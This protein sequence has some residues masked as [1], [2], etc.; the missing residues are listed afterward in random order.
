MLHIMFLLTV[1]LVWIVPIPDRRENLSLLRT[2]N[3]SR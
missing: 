2:P 3:A 1:P